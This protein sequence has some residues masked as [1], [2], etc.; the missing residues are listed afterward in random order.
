MTGTRRK[1]VRLSTA[2][3]PSCG[4]VGVLRRIL[5]G[6]PSADFDFDKFIVGGC[7]VTDVDPEVGCVKC[8]WVGKRDSLVKGSSARSK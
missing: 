3:C 6:M 1:Y 2:S 8:D 4:G 7:C 5:Y